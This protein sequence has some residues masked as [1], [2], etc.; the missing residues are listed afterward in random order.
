[1]AEEKKANDEVAVEDPAKR[2]A[3]LEKK[4]HA[5]SMTP[6]ERADDGRPWKFEPL[7]HNEPSRKDPVPRLCRDFV[8]QGKSTICM[9]SWI[10][11]NA[12]R[13]FK[14]GCQAGLDGRI[15]F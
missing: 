1:M 2:V 10:C 6:A 14:H 3:E 7:P 12:R 11:K 13:I 15:G 5:I 8:P 4:L 9:R